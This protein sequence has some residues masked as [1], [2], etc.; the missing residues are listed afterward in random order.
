MV[1]HGKLSNEQYS[2]SRIFLTQKF[3]S[4]IFQLMQFFL[5]WWLYTSKLQISAVVQNQKT[6]SNIFHKT[7][8]L[9]FLEE[10]IKGHL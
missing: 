1:N 10:H 6:L 8:L 3:S 5:C 2:I 7:G 9:F 4:Y